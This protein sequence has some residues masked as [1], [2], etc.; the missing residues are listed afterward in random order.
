MEKITNNKIKKVS[1]KI[2][3]PIVKCGIKEIIE[4]E[5]EDLKD[6]GN[7]KWKTNLK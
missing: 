6:G 4:I 2:I 3:G 1:Q 7:K 5:K